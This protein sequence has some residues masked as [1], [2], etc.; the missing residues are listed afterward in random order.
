MRF[1]RYPKGEPYQITPRKRAAAW[2]AV[3]KEKD[4]Y[5]LFLELVKHHTAEDR[6]ASIADQRERWWHEMRERHANVWRKARQALR[7]LPLGPRAAKKT[8]TNRSKWD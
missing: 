7:D 6:L 5:P 3:Q 1:T 8:T 4:R 2:R